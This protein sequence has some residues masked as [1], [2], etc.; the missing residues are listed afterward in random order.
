MSLYLLFK[1]EIIGFFKSKVMVLL[2]IGMP[3]LML[4]MRFLIPSNEE[5]PVTIV[6]LSTIATLAGSLGGVML[7]TGIVS[8]RTKGVYDLFL[9]RPVRRHEI[10]L[11]KF[12]SVIFCL[13]IASTISIL[14]GVVYDV[15]SESLLDP[16]ELL[17]NNIE[18]LIIVAASMSISCSF[19]IFMAMALNSVAAVGV[20]TYYLGSYLSLLIILPQLYF[21]SLDMA[22]VAPILGIG[23]TSVLLYISTILFKKKMN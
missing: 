20:L 3:L 10:V 4:L 16:I 12:L 7:G 19:G 21:E 2:W 14:V 13:V 5:M 17:E 18:G 1:D 11:A 8:E 15:A 23:I 9:I 22:I 6:S